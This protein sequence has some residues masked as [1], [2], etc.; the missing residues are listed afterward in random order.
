[1][2][3][4]FSAGFCILQQ[5]IE[6]L[7]ADLDDGAMLVIGRH[8]DAFGDGSEGQEVA[9]RDS[10]IF[11]RMVLVE[12]DD[13]FIAQQEGARSFGIGAAEGCGRRGAGKCIIGSVERSVG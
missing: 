2:V 9:C 1:M 5:R 3:G 8:T 12:V 13:P 7:A 10:T 11:L 4:S 6:L